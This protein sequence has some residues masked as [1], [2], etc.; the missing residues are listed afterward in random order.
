MKWLL[1]L[2]TLRYILSFY[3]AIALFMASP[4]LIVLFANA[5]AYLSGC[6]ENVQI[7]NEVCTNGDLIYGLSQGGWLLVFT[8]PLGLLALG[9]LLFVHGALYLLVKKRT[10]LALF[11]WERFRRKIR[12]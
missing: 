10:A 2:L 6:P 8:L 5:L 12:K 9:A 3:G 11:L 4:L 1:Q 7:S